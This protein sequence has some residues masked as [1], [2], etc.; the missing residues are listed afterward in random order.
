[1]NQVVT[2]TYLNKMSFESQIDDFKIVLSSEGNGPGPKKMMLASLAACSGLDVVSILNKMRIEFSE[3]SLTTEAHLTEEHPK[4]YDEVTL[5]YN[6]KID[7]K[8]SDKVLHAINLS[9]NKYCG[10]MEM[11]RKFADVKTKVNFI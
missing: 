8:Y 6:I 7:S 9:V 10:V 4:I 11:F 5:I 2:T 3:F 1:M